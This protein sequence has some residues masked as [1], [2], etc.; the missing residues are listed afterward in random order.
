MNREELEER[1]RTRRPGDGGLRRGTHLED[2]DRPARGGGYVPFVPEPDDARAV[3]EEEPDEPSPNVD[4][5]PEDV[6]WPRSDAA[7]DAGAEEPPPYAETTYVA[8][9]EAGAYD[10][11]YG[12]PEDAY[13]LPYAETGGGGRR[14]PG[15][16]P[17]IGFIGLCVLA[18]G[19]G[20]ALAS[21]LGGGPGVADE[22]ASPSATA[23]LEASFEPTA[24]PTEQPS[25]QTSATPGAT[26]EPVVFPD[27]AQLAIQPCSTREFDEDAVGQP[28]EQACPE[29]SSSIEGDEV[30]AFIV[31]NDTPGSDNLT[32]Q[33]L[34]NDEVVNE[35][36]I[37]IDGALG[38]S[39]G[40][41][42]NGLIYGAHYAGLFPGEYQLVLKRDGELADSAT[43]SVEG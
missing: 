3:H 38:G 24:E 5:A 10:E 26:D 7:S 34:E 32:V 16:L 6:D 28:E 43:F 14:G 41:S 31:F 33:L 2:D 18:L 36:E 30:W 11:P 27:G 21:V 1:I 40:S 13:P 15:A 9:H 20:A 4:N 25:G 12:A 39:C 8:P 42:C 23:S 37:T 35:Q 17:I 19:V 29:D 22:S